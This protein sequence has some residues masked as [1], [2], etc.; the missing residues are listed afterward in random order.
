M[1]R[2]DLLK[3]LSQIAKSKGLELREE[4][5][6]SHTKVYIG[7][8]QSVVPRHGEINEMTARSIIKH[9]GGSK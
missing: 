9:F 5:G 2:R 6:A 4:E 7:D 1:K 8:K 3:Q